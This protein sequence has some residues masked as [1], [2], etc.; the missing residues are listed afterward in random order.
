VLA[1]SW[2]GYGQGWGTC[3]VHSW[4]DD[5]RGGENDEH[6]EHKCANYRSTA[7]RVNAKLQHDDDFYRHENPNGNISN[8]TRSRRPVAV[9]SEDDDTE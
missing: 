2:N 5:Y 6:E 8:R 9:D 1:T 4:D 3:S 7:K